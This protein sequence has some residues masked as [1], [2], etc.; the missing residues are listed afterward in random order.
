MTDQAN[1][2]AP[3]VTGGQKLQDTLT[4]GVAHLLAENKRLASVL[5]SQP[6]FTE[7]EYK[8]TLAYLSDVDQAGHAW[9]REARLWQ[10]I[11][12]KIATQLGKKTP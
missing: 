5:A 6:A 8:L 9:K 7:E 12:D 11:S 2:V 3:T 1:L 4:A 10:S